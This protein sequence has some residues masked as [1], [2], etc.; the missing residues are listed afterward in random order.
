M[1]FVMLFSTYVKQV[2]A[3]HLQ[4]NKHGKETKNEISD[5]ILC[6]VANT[7]KESGDKTA[8][9]QFHC[10]NI[11]SFVPQIKT[12]KTLKASI[13]KMKVASEI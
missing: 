4:D 5:V 6:F 7:W 11:G 13:G 1:I 10:Y 2:L 8:I 3:K 9:I 12:Y